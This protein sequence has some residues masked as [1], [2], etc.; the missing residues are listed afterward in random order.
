MEIVTKSR[1]KSKPRAKW[2]ADC[3]LPRPE[4]VKMFR[5][6]PWAAKELAECGAR[7]WW[8]RRGHEVEMWSMHLWTDVQT[9]IARIGLLKAAKDD[10][11]KHRIWN[12]EE[13]QRCNELFAV[14]Y[15]DDTLLRHMR[16]LNH[17]HLTPV[18]RA[19]VAI[20]RTATMAIAHKLKARA[21]EIAAKFTREREALEAD[22]TLCDSCLEEKW[23]E[24]RRQAMAAYAEVEV[25]CNAQVVATDRAGQA[26]LRRW[27]GDSV[28]DSVITVDPAEMSATLAAAPFRGL[29][30]VPKPEEPLA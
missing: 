1:G 20:T 4:G 15:A 26:F 7:V 14:V 18:L 19:M 23:E 17:D 25:Q 6:A 24:L 5:P 21:E 2:A 12:D 13:R 16:E 10:T 22:E 27:Y 29:R 9:Q 30:L 3:G 8:S 28:S 11:E